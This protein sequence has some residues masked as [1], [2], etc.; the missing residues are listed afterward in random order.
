MVKQKLFNTKTDS[1]FI[2][3]IRPVLLLSLT[4]INKSSRSSLVN[5]TKTGALLTN[6][7]IMNYNAFSI[8]LTYAVIHS[9]PSPYTFSVAKINVVL[10]SFPFPHLHIHPQFSRPRKGYEYLKSVRLLRTE[11]SKWQAPSTVDLTSGHREAKKR[12]KI[13]QAWAGDTTIRA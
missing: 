7:V 5:E 9:G 12:R 13:R 3:L 10:L 8:S 1:P 6:K 2:S 11:V 4:A